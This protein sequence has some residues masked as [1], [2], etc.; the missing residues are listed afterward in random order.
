M[1]DCLWVS[2]NGYEKLLQREKNILG[3][4]EKVKLRLGE[5]ARGDPDLPENIEFKELRIKTMFELPRQ[6]ADVREA[7]AKCQII[8]DSHDFKTAQFDTVCLGARVVVDYGEGDTETYT[9]LGYQEGDAANGF[10]SYLSPLGAALLGK[11]VGDQVTYNSPAGKISLKL[12]S[13]SKGI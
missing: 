7:L 12:L 3:E 8:E 1:K 4:I 2:R 5:S 10:L 13:V 6:L 11:K 9:I